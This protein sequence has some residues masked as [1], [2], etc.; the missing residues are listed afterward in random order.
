MRQVFRSCVVGADHDIM[1]FMKPKRPS[2][3]QAKPSDQVAC[4]FPFRPDGK[5]TLSKGVDFITLY[6]EARAWKNEQEKERLNQEEKKLAQAAKALAR[7]QSGRRSG[8]LFMNSSP[9]P[10]RRTRCVP[11]SPKEPA[12]KWRIN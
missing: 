11:F 9:P 12:M 6:L 7:K 8:S 4:Y 2:T 10:P 1:G 3:G 5:P